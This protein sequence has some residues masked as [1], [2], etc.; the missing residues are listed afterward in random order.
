MMPGW[1]DPLYG[2]LGLG[3]V[4]IAAAAVVAWFFPPF[5]KYA[6][7]V[8]GAVIAAA[9]IYAKGNRDRA[10]VES[11]RKEEAVRKAREAYDKIDARP[12]DP[13]T[14]DRRLRHGDF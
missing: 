11:R 1:F 4:I 14:V 10:A 13:G 2:W 7:V 3:G 5:R 12:D 8:I 9:S 6:L